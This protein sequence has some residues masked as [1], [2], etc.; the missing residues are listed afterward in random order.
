MADCKNY[1]SLCGAG[2]VVRDCWERPPIPAIPGYM[3][4]KN[5]VAAFCAANTAAPAC[6]N[7]TEVRGG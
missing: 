1:T 3:P 7:C 2:S 6:A 4:A 5:D